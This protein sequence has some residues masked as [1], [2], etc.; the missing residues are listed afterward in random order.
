MQETQTLTDP[1]RQEFVR[2]LGGMGVSLTCPALFFVAL[3]ASHTYLMMF[4]FLLHPTC[5][6]SRLW[7]PGYSQGGPC[8]PHFPPFPHN[9]PEILVPSLVAGSKPEC[10]LL[11]RES[12][13]TFK[14]QWSSEAGCKHCWCG[15]PGGRHCISSDT[16]STSLGGLTVPV[17]IPPH[18]HLW[19]VPH[20]GVGGRARWSE[21]EQGKVG[22]ASHPVAAA[23]GC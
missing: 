8:L 1:T 7:H 18:V 14:C 21:A 2:I 3:A 15:A 20:T 19:A 22:R 13:F 23:P 10:L 11:V 5:S 12:D 4:H 6:A 16:P 17:P 9:A